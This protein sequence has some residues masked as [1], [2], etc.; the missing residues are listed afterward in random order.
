MCENKKKTLIMFYVINGVALVEVNRQGRWIS[1]DNILKSSYTP[2]V[3]TLTANIYYCRYTEANY[4]HSLRILLV[5]NKFDSKSFFLKAAASCHSFPKSC[6]LD[7]YN[8]N[9][10]ILGS[11]IT[12][13]L[14]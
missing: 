11:T 12:Y 10:F 3:Q 9:I 14:N 2:R 8:L 1:M 13:P 5:R 6:F 4:R 7:K